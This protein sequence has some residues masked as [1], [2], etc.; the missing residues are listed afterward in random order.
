[1]PLFYQFTEGSFVPLPNVLTAPEPPVAVPPPPADPK[2][3][4]ALLAFLAHFFSSTPAVAPPATPAFGFPH[5]EGT[6]QQQAAVLGF[7]MPLGDRRQ[8]PGETAGCG[9]P[10]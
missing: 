10:R 8:R 9:G 7:L 2:A 3:F 1:M 6:D 4:D 5:A